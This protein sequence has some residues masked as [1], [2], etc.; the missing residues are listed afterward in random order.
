[1]EETGIKMSM[2]T[3]NEAFWEKI[4]NFRKTTAGFSLAQNGLLRGD[5]GYR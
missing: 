5:K 3:L 1:M 4:M 2:S